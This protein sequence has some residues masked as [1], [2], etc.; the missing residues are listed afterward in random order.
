LNETENRQQRTDSRK[1]TIEVRKR[2]TPVLAF[3]RKHGGYNVAGG[4]REGNWEAV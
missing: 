1:Q 3:A 4:V 2:M